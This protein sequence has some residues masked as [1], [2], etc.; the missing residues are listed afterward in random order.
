M[1]KRTEA[2]GKH[3]KQRERGAGGVGYINMDVLDD[4]G[5]GFWRSST[6][7]NFIAII[8]PKDADSYFGL[9]IFPHFNIG[10][11][12]ASFLCPRMMSGGKD[13]CPLCE[14]RRRLL[15]AG[16]EDEELLRDLNAYPPRFLYFIVDMTSADTEAEGV[17]LYD[18]PMTVDDE[19][20]AM[21]KDRRTGEL[22]DV[23]DPDDGFTVS[24]LREG[25]Q[26][27]TNYKAFKLEERDPLP[28][29][30]LDAVIPLEKVIV[31]GNYDE[32]KEAY[33]GDDKEEGSDEYDEKPESSKPRR[34]R[35][36]DD[37]EDEKPKRGRRPKRKPRQEE[38]TEDEVE[39]DEAPR[40][41]RRRKMVEESEVDDDEIPFDKDED[42]DENVLEKTKR[43]L[44]KKM[45][46]R[47]R[48]AKEDDE[49]DDD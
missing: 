43:R 30:W 41:R 20:L 36:T 33:F 2:I 3:S 10:F 34:S 27:R 21:S 18:A 19:I 26:R 42:E 31:V 7:D 28:D 11:N 45:A 48:K 12:S 16:C 29:E 17:Q 32:M 13:R 1:S 44:Q 38:K 46:E 47:K 6:G 24:F 5:L 14:E 23:S 39:D 15:D 8:P 35:K 9:E 49:E 40:K 37:E 25:A 4:A 22:L